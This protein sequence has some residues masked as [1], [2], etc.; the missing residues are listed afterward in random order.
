MTTVYDVFGCGYSSTPKPLFGTEYE[1]E[2]IKSHGKAPDFNII[3]TED[4]S[5]RNSGYEYKTTALDFETSLSTFKNLHAT[6][7]YGHPEEAFSERTS[8]HVHVNVAPLTLKEAREFV[9]L[10]ALYE[11]LFF[12]FAGPSREASI[13]C[14]PLYYTNFSKLF[15]LPFEK[16]VN[17]WSHKYTAFN[18]LP[19]K[20]FG[21]IEFRHLG[22][23]NDYNRYLAW[24]SAINSLY[25]FVKDHDFSLFNELKKGNDIVSLAHEVV[26][27]L[28]KGLS[29]TELSALFYD[30]LLDIKLSGGGI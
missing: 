9:L 13:F 24:L 8:T 1:I 6:I 3:V 10:Y 7:L 29:K 23:T 27:T 4:H 16:M 18:L 20:T 25:D 12:K 30:T 5:L 14:V 28:S 11:P 22:G 15:S 19:V 26:P 21:T 17:N 2:T